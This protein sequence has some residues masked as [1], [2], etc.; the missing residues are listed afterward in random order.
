MPEVD[1]RTR[2]ALS[3]AETTRDQVRITA[4][5]APDLW[6]T[7]KKVLDTLGGTYQPNHSAWSF[8]YD[9]GPTIQQI[10]RTGRYVNPVTDEG[11]VP[12]PAALAEE[13]T[14]HPYSDLGRMPAGSRVLEPSAGDGALVRAIL[15]ANDTIEVVALEPNVQ[16]FPHRR[17]KASTT[18]G[19]RRSGRRSRSTPLHMPASCSTPW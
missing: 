12:T 15:D 16:R 18:A 11:Y 9:P 1:G 4:Q 19:S 5:L 8:P 7:V 13:L 14:T 6:Q 2:E 10:G 17:T 3:A